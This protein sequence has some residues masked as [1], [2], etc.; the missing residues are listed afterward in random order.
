GMELIEVE[1]II[2]IEAISNYS[3]LYFTGGRTL[4]VAKVL[5]WFEEKLAVHGFIRVH[6]KHL[7]NKS[8]IRDYVR[9]TLQQSQGGKVELSN[10]EWISVSKRK[11]TY[12]LQY[13]LNSAA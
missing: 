11:N 3:K 5:R 8:Y 10:G 1:A 4:V 9:G 2:R 7:L 12:F 13:W 6:K